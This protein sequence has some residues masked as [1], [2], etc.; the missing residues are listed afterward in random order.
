MIFLA[1]HWSRNFNMYAAISLFLLAVGNFNK[2][3]RYYYLL[4]LRYPLFVLDL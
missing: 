2:R 3:L 4:L 1:F